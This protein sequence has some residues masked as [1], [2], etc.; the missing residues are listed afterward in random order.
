VEG[1]LNHVLLKLIIESLIL[2]L[3]VLEFGRV[4]DSLTLDVK[5]RKLINGFSN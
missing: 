4:C 3:A 1:M 5:N 2:N